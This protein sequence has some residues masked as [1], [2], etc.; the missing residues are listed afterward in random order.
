MNG[1]PDAVGSGMYGPPALR[2]SDGYNRCLTAQMARLAAEPVRPD[3]SALND[4][5]RDSIEA[6]CRNA[7]YREGPAAYDRC[8]VRFMKALV[9]SR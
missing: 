6:A 7:K 5:D 2:G 3:L 9:E 4:A 8:R 1:A